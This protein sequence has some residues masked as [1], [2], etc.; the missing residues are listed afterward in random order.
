[1]VC[2]IVGF[3]LA[4]YVT[5]QL[6]ALQPDSDKVDSR[7][8]PPTATEP[9]S[10]Q[11]SEPKE[12]TAEVRPDRELMVDEEGFPFLYLPEGAVFA[13]ATLR[14]WE[15][16]AKPDWPG[17]E[18]VG[19]AYNIV[20][21][22]DSAEGPVEAPLR[23]PV[24]VGLPVDLSNVDLDE[25]SPFA[26][27]QTGES[28]WV[29]V[30]SWLSDDSRR[31]H[32]TL[33]HFSLAA[34]LFSLSG[35]KPSL[36][37]PSVS[38]SPISNVGYPPCFDDAIVVS[39]TT[40]DPDHSVDSVEAKVVFKLKSTQGI[41]DTVK[42]TEQMY[43][44][45]LTIMVGD[46]TS[47][48]YW[49][50]HTT[51]V[52]QVG[53]AAGEIF[54]IGEAG[55]TAST[56]ESVETGWFEMVEDSEVPGSYTAAVKL[57]EVSHCSNLADWEPGAAPEGALL[58]GVEFVV[59]MNY[60]DG[61]PSEKKVPVDV[62]AGKVPYAQLFEPGPGLDPP[63][64][65]RPTFRWNIENSYLDYTQKLVYA[66]GDNLWDRFLGLGTKTVKLGW[67]ERSW[68]PPQDLDEGAWVWGIEVKSKE[69]YDRDLT[70]RSPM[71]A[72]R[73]GS[74]DD[75][76]TVL[77]DV[78]ATPN[79]GEAG[80]LIQVSVSG[81]PKGAPASVWLFEPGGTGRG[82]A[83]LVG[84]LKG[85]AQGTATFTFSV[86]P[87]MEAGDW[88]VTVVVEDGA[89]T[90]EASFEVVLP[91]VALSVDGT[92]VIRPDVEE[93]SDTLHWQIYRV[94]GSD[95]VASRRADLDERLDLASPE[96]DLE[97][98]TYEVELGAFPDPDDSFEYAVLS[99]RVAVEVVGMIV[100]PTTLPL[101]RNSSSRQKRKQ[102][103]ESIGTP[104]LVNPARSRNT[105]A[106]VNVS[107]PLRP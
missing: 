63:T 84:N 90:G 81:L 105:I 68:T 54:V 71:Y 28:P 85:T 61:P 55:L 15:V 13:P 25:G 31:L 78:L 32:F 101:T 94:G 6:P 36:D 42:F 100:S 47:V 37:Q 77:L 14:I 66:K 50:G 104:I 16:D 23:K 35:S 18:L 73:V 33:D 10:S 70:I 27:N 34:P 21:E 20:L 103:L 89:A 51:A 49:A 69:S 67:T 92:T 76:E 75:E 98:G 79:R 59:R 26:V 43:A 80:D 93:F 22:E 30:P 83:P 44:L 87:H 53:A 4:A 96:L 65:S 56:S 17:T 52:G 88:R 107:T 2:G 48:L 102:T 24:E 41:E 39:A 97:P 95:P 8:Y 45:G 29:E 72:F 86:E 74:E 40:D 7:S 1:M 9:K 60:D 91:S 82:S 99:S 46:A 5:L 3:L 57:T 106:V 12:W 62:S 58:D 11:L 19:P 38:P 64:S